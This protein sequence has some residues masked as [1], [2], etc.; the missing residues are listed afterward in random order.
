MPPR[1]NLGLVSPRIE[2]CP[3]NPDSAISR[4]LVS[5]TCDEKASDIVRDTYPQQPRVTGSALASRLG[6][7]CAHGP[8]VCLRRKVHR[9]LLQTFLSVAPTAARTSSVLRA[10]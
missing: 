4:V 8:R 1:K 6:P 3:Q 7:R 2:L 5:L 9:Y 10:S